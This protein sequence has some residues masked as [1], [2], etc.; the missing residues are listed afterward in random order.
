VRFRFAGC[1]LDTGAYRLEV[2]GHPEPVE[3]QVFDLLVYLIEH[4]DRVVPKEELLDSIWGDRFVSESALTSRLKSARRAVGDDGRSQRVIRTVHGRGY[5]FVAPVEQDE[6]AGP[7]DRAPAVPTAAVGSLPVP[8]TP[9]VGR[10]HEL[11]VLTNLAAR[12][13][14]L[15][16]TG[17]GGVGKTRLTVELA[18][19]LADRYPDGARFVSLTSVADP[20][21]VPQQV[22]EALGL[23]SDGAGPEPVL[24]ELLRGRTM[25]LVVDNF[26]H[27][28]EAAPFISDMLAWAPGL[29]VLATSRERLRLAGE[30]V[31]E[32]L[33]L[34]VGRDGDRRHHGHP[35]EASLLF[36]Q[37][38]RAVDPSFAIDEA[39]EADVAAICRA[40][41]GLPL[42]VELA[43]AQVR[44]LPASVL[45]DRLARRIDALSGGMRD[46]PSR[47]QTMRATIAWSYDLLPRDE[48]RLFDR[49]GVFATSASLEAIERVCAVDDEDDDLL[50]HLA[51]LVDKS[52]VRRVEGRHGEPRFTMLE[53][54][55]DFAVERLDASDE[56]DEIRRRHALDVLDLVTGY[57][58]ARWRDAAHWIDDVNELAADI[59]A[60]YEWSIAA[61]ELGTAAGI[62]AALFG[63]TEVN[64]V[65]A[66]RWIAQAVEWIDDVDVLT[67]GRLRLGAGY[68]ELLKGDVDLARAQWQQALERFRE[69]AHD[70]YTAISLAYIAA[71]FIG[72]PTDYELA[73]RLCADAVGIARPV[74]EQPV[75][76]QILNIEGEL[77]RVQGDDDRARVAY[78]MAL[79][80]ARAGHEPGVESTVLANLSYLATHR[81]DYDEAHRLGLESLRMC[82]GLGL[83]SPAAWGLGELAG[84]ELGRGRTERAA[85]LVGASD[86]ALEALGTSR[87]PGD[88]PEHE[89]VVDELEHA[90]GP[91]RLAAL[92]AEGAAM[93]L[94]ECV[95]EVL[96]DG[97]PDGA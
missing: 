69:L 33:P 22:A 84:A 80:A 72:S 59:R 52:L 92:R 44:V 50:A 24:H 45:R 91:E 7:P 23:R 25:L 11:S 4:R 48:R 62:V 17:P 29:S 67:A 15:T 38:A 90:L 32:V 5:Q 43:A 73:L 68:V 54:L 55:R 94:E 85:R 56:S 27:V 96:A 74:G 78:R 61:G 86:A 58:E 18:S 81:G 71:T 20:Q 88:Q 30:Q 3:P 26:E 57:E 89:R 87:G 40:V 97:Q 60:A 28:V 63:Y 64:P 77:A 34:A 46:R 39:N 1:E 83:R 2:A 42:A 31:Y 12:T 93:T 16:L 51:G 65:Q 13:R 37:S 41:D 36:E 47:H 66:V 8:A 53:L 75:M 82:W 95:R 70:R 14:L 79:D 6:V 10:R 49:L 19:R 9:L 21:L 76:A 35:S